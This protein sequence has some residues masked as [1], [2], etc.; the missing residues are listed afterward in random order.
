MK[1]TKIQFTELMKGRFGMSREGADPE[2][3]TA[4]SSARCRRPTRSSRAATRSTSTSLTKPDAVFLT[5]DALRVRSE[6]APRSPS[7]RPS[8]PVRRRERR[9]PD[10]RPADPGGPD[11]LR[12]GD[13]ADVRLRRRREGSARS[14]SKRVRA[15]CRTELYGTRCGTTRQPGSSS[16]TTRRGFSSTTSSP[17]IRP[18]A[19]YPDLG[20]SAPKTRITPQQ[21]LKFQR[22]ARNATERNGFTG[23]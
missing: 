19:L 14:S 8:A 18:K 16:S 15:S 7:S 13:R 6:P 3:R 11:H 10:D 1:L 12:L 20:G 9:R 17:G 5:S 23:H 22:P 21:R 2:N 4:T